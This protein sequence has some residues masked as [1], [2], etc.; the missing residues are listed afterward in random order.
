[1]VTRKTTRTTK[2]TKTAPAAKQRAAR[3]KSAQ[4]LAL[5]PAPVYQLKVTLKGFRP[6]IW[7]RI[8]VKGDIPLGELHMI[9]QL[10]MGWTNSHLHHFIIGKRPHLQFIGSARF[11]D[12]LDTADEDEVT[13]SQ[14]LPRAKT[15]IAYEYDFGDGWEHEVTLEKIIAAEPGVAYPRCVAGENACPPEDVGGVWGYANFLH[16]L[17]DPN[18]DEHDTYVEWIGGAFD[19]QAFDLAAA[20]R[21]LKRVK[22]AIA[23]ARSFFEEGI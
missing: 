23:F 13:I 9:I 2:T 7:R 15:K 12:G 16:A 3:K 8:Q 4:P 19:P 21:R 14:V 18:H 5:A 20:N 22:Q 1:M 6:T 17:Q 11:D 10:A